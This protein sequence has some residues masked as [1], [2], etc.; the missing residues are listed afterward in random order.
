MSRSDD[1]R[2]AEYALGL[3]RGEERR[4]LEAEITTDA[5]LQGKVA[6]WQRWL[7]AVDEAGADEL[8]DGMFERILS[9][10]DNDGLRAP[11]TVTK[12]AA[13]AQ[14]LKYS[15]GITYRVLNV[16]EANKR[17]SLLVRMEPGAVYR[18]HVHDIDEE[19]L[20]IEGDLRYGD[21]E[22]RAGDFHLATPGMIHPTGHTTSGCL[23]HVVV[24]LDI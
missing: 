19:C 12:R 8:P 7:S 21:L 3:L 16:D 20:I 18:S 13:L 15:P 14:W 1:E 17:Q 9:R 6:S 2:S 4:A 24:G 10:I 23:L 22:L 11:G 5:A